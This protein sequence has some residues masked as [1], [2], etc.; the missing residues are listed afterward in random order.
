MIR[1][2]LGD[3]GQNGKVK[4]INAPGT[5]I[6]AEEVKKK[7]IM[8]NLNSNYSKIQNLPNNHGQPSSVPK[9]LG[10]PNIFE[11]KIEIVITN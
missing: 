10:K 6:R 4:N 2:Y 8:I 3:S 9:K 7:K 5:T 11:S 1:M